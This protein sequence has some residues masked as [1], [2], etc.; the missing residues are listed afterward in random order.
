MSQFTSLLV[1]RFSV[2]PVDVEKAEQFQ[3]KNGGRLERIL[4]NMGAFSSENLPPFYSELLGFPLMT[5]SQAE[6]VPTDAPAI[7]LTQD[8]QLTELS[9]YILAVDDAGRARAC[10]LSDPLDLRVNEWIAS[11]PQLVDIHLLTEDADTVLSERYSQQSEEATSSLTDIEEDRLRELAS[12]APVVNLLN[13]LIARAL[14]QGASDMHVEP[15]GLKGRVR[16]RIDGVLH[17]VETIPSS[18]V[19]PVITR[20]KI[21][22]NMDIAEKRRPQDGKIQ[23]KVDGK[24]VDI[25]VSALPVGEGGESVV[26]RF[27]L[28]ESLSY[29]IKALGIEPDTEKL[30]L[31]DIQTTSGVILMTGP[32]GSGKTTSLYSFLSRRNSEDVKII[33]LEDPVEYRLPGIN[34][35]AV[36]SEIGYDFAKALRSVVRQDP[37]IIMVGEIRD[38]ETAN[39]SMQAALTGH[40][41][42][43]TLHTN[44]APTA[45]TR[46]LDLGVEE[47]LINSAVKSIVAQRL[48]RK[49]CPSCKQPATDADATVRKYQL[50]S[51][52]KEQ[53]LE[54]QLRQ[55]NGCEE[56]NHTGYRGR[57][58]IIEYMRCDDDIQALEKGERFLENAR[59]HNRDKGYRNLLQDGFVKVIKGET[60]IEEV[61]RVAG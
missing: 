18:M 28:Q 49:L 37:D 40:L 22:S 33:T 46:L 4:Q 41:V 17:E 26:M 12:E 55:A 52:C 61:L 25:R 35:V 3:A 36:Q 57:L 48:V 51:L 44:D 43:S 56:C 15:S 50:D 1:D 31:E 14:R 13:A 20:L 19:L 45:Y 59:Q 10:A 9:V 58:A 7:S 23:M 11:Q 5:L 42:F 39:I 54:L 29:D 53:N 60:T 6:N 47:F 21:L 30:L 24:S 27:L 38:K 2:D 16:Y 8:Y 32:T 34:Q